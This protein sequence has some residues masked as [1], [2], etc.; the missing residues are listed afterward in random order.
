M[1]FTITLFEEKRQLF[2]FGTIFVF[3]AGADFQN[4]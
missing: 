3:I 2:I 4:H 1:V